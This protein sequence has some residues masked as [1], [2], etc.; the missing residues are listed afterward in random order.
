MFRQ[1]PQARPATADSHPSP[2]SRLG[3][4]RH[5]CSRKWN[6]DGEHPRYQRR[7]TRLDEIGTA[8][9]VRE[10]NGCK[11]RSPARDIWRPDQKRFHLELTENARPDTVPVVPTR[12]RYTDPA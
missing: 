4:R 3:V 1:S 9:Y 8:E 11:A 6:T 10:N 2:A 12:P 7:R 5:P